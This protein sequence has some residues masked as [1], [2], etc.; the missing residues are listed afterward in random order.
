MKAD[1]RFPF[2]SPYRIRHTVLGWNT[3]AQMPMVGHRMPLDQCD[4]HGLA[5][6]P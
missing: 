5:E 2:Q 6:R 1:G 3:Q 4:T